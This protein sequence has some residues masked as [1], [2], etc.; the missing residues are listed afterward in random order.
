MLCQCFDKPANKGVQTNEYLHRLD[1][2]TKAGL[3]RHTPKAVV[4]GPMKYG[5]LNYPHFKTIQTTK[6]VMYLIKQLRWDKEMEKELRVNIEMTQLMAG[7]V[8]PI[9]ED[10]RTSIDYLEE[11]WVLTVR[12][13]L[14][15]LDAKVW[16]K[17]I[18]SP[19]KQREGDIGI[20]EAVGCIPGIN[21]AQLRAVNMC[22][23][24]LKVIMV[25][26]MANIQGTA[27]PPG[28]MLCR[29]RRDSTLS[30]QD[31]PCPSPKMWEIF[32]WMMMKALG[33][34]A[35]VYN[36]ADEMPL[37]KK[38]RKWMRVERHICYTFMRN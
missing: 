21:E 33:T 28:R 30:W 4:Y 18:W 2:I 15:M 32:R 14:R 10:P 23:I 5:G 35:R 16:I 31:L 38:M 34:M 22:R 25:S 26:E 11:S 36:P 17:Y 1:N 12:K 9:M 3:N 19:T 37:K 6:S 7:V 29:W 13:R 20:M 27:I 24:Y 8:T